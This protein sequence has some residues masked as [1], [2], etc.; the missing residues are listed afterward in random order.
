MYQTLA[1]IIVFA[2]S[3]LYGV[4]EDRFGWWVYIVLVVTTSSILSSTLQR[5]QQ[6]KALEVYIQQLQVRLA[7]V[8][9][10]R[11]RVGTTSQI[12]DEDLELLGDS[13]S[14]LYRAKRM[15]DS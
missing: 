10:I 13:E 1:E 2:V 9:Q 11:D 3:I 14:L 12:D 7:V 4:S 6:R 15:V 5:Y 8:Q